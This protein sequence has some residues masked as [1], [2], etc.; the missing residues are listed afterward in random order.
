M[1]SNVSAFEDDIGS[2]DFGEVKTKVK[3]DLQC[4]KDKIQELV[5]YTPQSTDQLADRMEGLYTAFMSIFSDMSDMGWALWW[6]K[7]GELQTTFWRIVSK[8]L[9][10][11]AGEKQMSVHFCS[12][13]FIEHEIKEDSTIFCINFLFLIF[14]VVTSP[15]GKT[16]SKGLWRPSE[17]FKYKE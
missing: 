17:I 16:S 4:V 1:L 5:D 12:V 2:A 8:K 15:A 14:K 7:T 3:E 13:S 6:M 10:P 9:H 11:R